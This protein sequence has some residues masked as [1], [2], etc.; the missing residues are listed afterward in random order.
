LFA[1]LE[2]LFASHG[3]RPSL[4]KRRRQQKHAG[5]WFRLVCFINLVRSANQF[6]D[7]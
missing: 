2:V 7:F 6:F 4:E 5:H 1:C 3:L